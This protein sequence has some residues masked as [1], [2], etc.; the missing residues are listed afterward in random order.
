MRYF[1]TYSG[2]FYFINPITSIEGSSFGFLLLHNSKK[3]VAFTIRP[4]TIVM[5]A[6]YL[7]DIATY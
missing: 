4:D 3:T 6:S 7:C 2:N 5:P 1:A